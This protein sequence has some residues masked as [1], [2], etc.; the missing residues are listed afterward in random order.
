MDYLQADFLPNFKILITLDIQENI[1]QDV[2]NS[3]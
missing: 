1:L 2:Y 3:L